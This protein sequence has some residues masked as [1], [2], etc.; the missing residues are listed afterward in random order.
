M[1]TRSSGYP[2]AQ[3]RVDLGM[4][5][6]CMIEMRIG[7]FIWET[8]EIQEHGTSTYLCYLID[9]NTRVEGGAE[10]EA[11]EEWRGL[12]H[13]PSN[14]KEARRERPEDGK[15]ALKVSRLT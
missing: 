3:T 4:C 7:P 8:L 15:V 1:V 12:R 13:S 9:G 14:I 2:R 5:R 6:Y 11:N 10:Q